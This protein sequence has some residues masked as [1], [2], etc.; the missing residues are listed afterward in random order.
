MRTH[1]LETHSRIKS[2]TVD[3]KD[4]HGLRFYVPYMINGDQYDDIYEITAALV[5]EDQQPV[6]VKYERRN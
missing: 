1:Y 4:A 2:I 6:K 5:D 3:L